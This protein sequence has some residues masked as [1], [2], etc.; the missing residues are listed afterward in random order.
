[1]S[2]LKRIK[3]LA[4]QLVVAARDLEAK[5]KAA[6]DAKTEYLRLEREDL[7]DLMSE[8][9]L[10]EI[11]LD[12]GTKISVKE[13]CSAAITAKNKTTAHA[14]LVD[15]GFGGLIRTQLI[16]EFG[17]GEHDDAIEIRDILAS[18]Y[19]IDAALT[20]KVHPATLKSFVKEQMEKGAA[21]PMEL[22]SVHPYSKAIIKQKG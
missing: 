13:D 15:N 5:E 6:K 12:D 10:S 16:S 18:E 22:F 8:I 14:W 20:E 11:V 2:D 19:H 7:P 9:G 1:M 21:I 17:T 3:E 4:E